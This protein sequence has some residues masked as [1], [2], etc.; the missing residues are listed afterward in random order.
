M[1]EKSVFQK[2]KSGFAKLKEV[3]KEK[4]DFRKKKSGI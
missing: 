1:K 2:K 3:L 4:S